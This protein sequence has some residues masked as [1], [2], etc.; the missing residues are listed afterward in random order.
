MVMNAAIK[1]LID[2]LARNIFGLETCRAIQRGG[3]HGFVRVTDRQNKW[4]LGG[5]FIA[6][7]AEHHADI[8]VA[9]ELFPQRNQSFEGMLPFG[10]N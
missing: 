10:R 2:N 9:G 5:A 8:R 7:V 3:H 4:K 6:A 1:K